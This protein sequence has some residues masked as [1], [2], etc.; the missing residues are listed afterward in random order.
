MR[1]HAAPLSPRP[2]AVPPHDG[3][4]P[5]LPCHQC[6][7]GGANHQ[8]PPTLANMY[9][10]SNTRPTCFTLPK[11]QPPTL[12]PLCRAHKARPD[13]ASAWHDQRKRPSPALLLR[14]PPIF[15]A[16]QPSGQLPLS[17]EDGRRWRGWCWDAKPQWLRPWQRRGHGAP[18]HGLCLPAT[19]RNDAAWTR[20][21]TGGHG[22]AGAGQ[23]CMQAHRRT[24]PACALDPAG[25]P[26]FWTLGPPPVAHPQRHLHAPCISH[27]SCSSR[28]PWRLALASHLVV[29]GVL[30]GP[31]P[32]L[33]GRRG[34]GVQVCGVGR[35]WGCT[36]PAAGQ[37][38]MSIRAAAVRLQGPR[39]HR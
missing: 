5:C 6:H 16:C 7:R 20:T 22:A 24:R 26:P 21:C 15:A 10:Y 12:I 4:V 9:T 14:L 28:L 31:P 32:C 34:W 2:G 29:R 18:G 3:C 33:E 1:P 35:C 17:A 36:C 37:V 39:R 13:R 27:S 23:A 19:A 11:P 30:E 8:A 38:R 25:R